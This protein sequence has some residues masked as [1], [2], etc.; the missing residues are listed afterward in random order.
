MPHLISDSVTASAAL[1][2]ITQVLA[3]SVREDVPPESTAVLAEAGLDPSM[4]IGFQFGLGMAI[5]EPLWARRVL[6]LLH[7]GLDQDIVRRI[8]TLWPIPD[9]KG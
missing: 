1:V 5:A 9:A 3:A 8:T 4:L 6:G 7:H 2:E